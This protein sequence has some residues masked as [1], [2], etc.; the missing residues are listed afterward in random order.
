MLEKLFMEQ[1]RSNVITKFLIQDASVVMEDERK[2]KPM[3]RD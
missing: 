1:Q 2:I 3:A